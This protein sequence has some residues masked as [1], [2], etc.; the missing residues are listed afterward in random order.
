MSF[1]IELNKNKILDDPVRPESD[2]GHSK[3]MGFDRW[4][5]FE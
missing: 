3:T 4:L 5:V 2:L 1:Q